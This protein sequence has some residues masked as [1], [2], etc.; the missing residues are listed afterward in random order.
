MPPP[1]AAVWASAGCSAAASLAS[2][3]LLGSC[4]TSASALRHAASLAPA[5]GT[6]PDAEHGLRQPLLSDF[7]GQDEERPVAPPPAVKKGASLYRLIRLSG[8]DKFKA[9][10][11]FI[12]LV[13]AV[14]CDVA[15]PAFKSDALT[16]ILQHHA[17]TLLRRAS[18][19]APPPPLFSSPPG[20]DFS[21]AVLALAV[22]SAGAGLFSGLRGGLLSIC[23]FRLVMR[24]QLSLYGRLIRK[25][26]A[27]LDELSTGKMLSRLTTDTSML[28]DV[29]GLNLNVA[30]RSM[31]RLILC[32][33][34]LCTLSVP[35][36]LLSLGSSLAF[37]T[38]TFFFSRYQRVSS[39]AV[40]EAT[41]D[42]NH[43]AEQSLSLARTVR[44]FGAEVWEEQRFSRVLSS[45][46]SV[47]ERQALAYMLYTIAFGILDNAQSVVLL[48][49]GGHLYASGA[50]DGAVLSKF[51]FYSAV[52]SASIQSIADMVGDLFKAL[53]ASEEVFRLIDEPVRF[54]TDDDVPPCDDV[55]CIPGNPAACAAVSF[56][57]VQFA[58]PSR[59]G[60]RVLNGVNL[61][62]APGQQVAVCG[63]SGSGKST[64][65]QLLLRFY[66][67]DAGRVTLNEH[68]IT[69]V[70]VRW[71]RKMMS[72]VGQEPPLFSVSL[73]QN[74]AYAD[75]G[76]SDA[77]VEAAA[78]LAC[79]TSFIEAMPDKYAT[80]VGPK[81]IQLSG[82]Q[83]QRIAIARAIIRNP[84]LLILVRLFRVCFD[85][86][87]FA[88]ECSWQDEAT[89]ALDAES[90]RAVQCALEQA[91]QGRSVLVVAHRLSTI[92]NADIIVVMRQGNIV[93]TGTHAELLAK[94][95][96]YHALVQG[97]LDVP[98]ESG[99]C[100]VAATPSPAA[101]NRGRLLLQHAAE[102]E[103]KATIASDSDSESCSSAAP[104]SSDT[105]TSR[106]SRSSQSGSRRAGG[107]PPP[108]ANGAR[109]SRLQQGQ[110]S[111]AP[112]A[113]TSSSSV[114]AP[115]RPDAASLGRA[116]G[117]RGGGRGAGQATERGGRG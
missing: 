85:P 20:D 48:V 73:R 79:A 93:E 101:A 80:L 109:G 90:E 107:L 49:V 53:G 22:A 16:A 9:A 12:F 75:D 97:Q 10:G 95:G 114:G 61:R 98:A 104:A 87:L 84:P 2:L 106:P 23:N 82:G 40:Q 44:A 115:I 15:I 70:S 65:I 81:G 56:E 60:V 51:V 100:E 1:P 24:L 59:L 67:A 26:I 34:Y 63:L 36:T 27:T 31:L 66:D 45:R 8:P 52:V 113:S 32:V 62:V 7:Q 89:S 39:R 37:F 18:G 99:C 111:P 110:R 77:D 17:S 25:D 58:Y 78:S 108:S 55:S 29:L 54:H 5:G 83:K 94:R 112:A 64:L 28:G 68:D 116:A 43:V 86:L 103:V 46:L 21:R 72:V 50:V 11:A 38:V 6:L 14:I 3:V 102:L 19:E 30:L 13:L 91:M 4:A 76:Y 92:R 35:L 117:G 41:A 74:V 71:L 69:Q 105:P 42:S 33:G 57:D 88:A 47:Q 96:A